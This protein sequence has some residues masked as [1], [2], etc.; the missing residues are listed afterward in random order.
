MLPRS[1][2]FHWTNS[3]LQFHAHTVD[4]ILF[5]CLNASTFWLNL[6]STLLFIVNFFRSTFVPTLSQ[7]LLVY[8]GYTIPLVAI[9]LIRL[10]QLVRNLHR[11]ILLKVYEPPYFYKI[12][13]YILLITSPY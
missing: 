8:N 4:L 10:I 1:R 7:F 5:L 2:V 9:S 11:N 3:I 13:P 12:R 6:Y